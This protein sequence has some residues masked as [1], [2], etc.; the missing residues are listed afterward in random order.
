MLN[1]D[2]KPQSLQSFL[3]TQLSETIPELQC[4]NNTGCIFKKFQCYNV[5]FGS[6]RLLLLNLTL[7]FQKHV[8]V[9]HCKMR[10]RNVLAWQEVLRYYFNQNL[11]A[12]AI[13]NFHFVLLYVEKSCKK[14]YFKYCSKVLISNI[15]LKHEICYGEFKLWFSFPNDVIKSNEADK[16]DKNYRKCLTPFKHLKL[17]ASKVRILL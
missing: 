15:D 1:S 3:C 16:Q 14:C 8:N 7:H 12:F 4:Y 17:N 13:V 10:K 11:L 6:Y 9:I 2:T 5:Y